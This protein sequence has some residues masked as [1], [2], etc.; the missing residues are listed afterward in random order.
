MTISESRAAAASTHFRVHYP[1]SRP[2]R[3]KIIG[4]GVGGDRIAQAI[5]QR[6]LADVEIIIT[7]DDVKNHAGAVVKGITDDVAGLHRHLQ[8]A[9]IIFMVAVSGDEVT[10]AHAV[11]R[12][13]RELGKQVTGV[14]IEAQSGH[15]ANAAATLESLRACVD[16]LVIGSDETYLE[17][18]LGEL[19]AT[20][21]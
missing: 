4:L 1:N 5:R 15:S 7:G 17:E 21:L 12:V 20:A 8:E 3:I 13:I 16:M 6:G 19:G 11:S 18:M 14:L 2:R 10:F 9:E